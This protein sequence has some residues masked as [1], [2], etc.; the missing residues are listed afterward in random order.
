M[1]AVLLLGQ[2][3]SICSC[4]GS[5][6]TASRPAEHACPAVSHACRRQCRHTQHHTAGPPKALAAA[7]TFLAAAAD[8][9]QAVVS[10]SQKHAC[11]YRCAVLSH[12]ACGAAHPLQ[13]GHDPAGGL[14]AEQCTGTHQG[15]AAWVLQ[16]HRQCLLK[17]AQVGRQ[18][19]QGPIDW[20]VLP[21]VCAVLFQ[22]SLRLLMTTVMIAG[23]S[24]GAAMS[25]AQCQHAAVAPQC[26]AA[27]AGGQQCRHCAQHATRYGANAAAAQDAARICA[28]P[29]A[30]GQVLG[31]WAHTATRGQCGGKQH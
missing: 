26:T 12:P 27:A 18:L 17:T 19:L 2:H 10:I 15:A 31:W 14:C 11:L 7:L 8:G 24:R 23:S 16:V 21:V 25:L 22:P 30:T 6:A 29:G 3:R 13:Q 28:D 9:Q 5:T 1:A 4:C 20:Y